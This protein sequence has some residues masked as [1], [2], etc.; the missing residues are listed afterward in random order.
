MFK[1]N[2]KG[3]IDTFKET[4]DQLVDALGGIE[5]IT[6]AFHCATR[7]RVTVKD[8]SKVKERPTHFTHPTTPW[9]R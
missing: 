6:N 7:F 3:K 9:L 4:V 2:E 8:D 1:K 5:N